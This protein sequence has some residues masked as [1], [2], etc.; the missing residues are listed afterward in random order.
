[1]STVRAQQHRRT[2]TETSSMK[3]TSTQLIE[4]PL[5][6]H[7]SFRSFRIN[8]HLIVMKIMMMKRKK[9]KSKTKMMMMKKK[10]LK[11]RRLKRTKKMTQISILRYRQAV[12]IKKE[13]K[14]LNK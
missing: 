11:T 7:T 6:S 10:K 8:F 12:T 4:H 5:P 3:K 2:S 9:N 13:K 14:K 1:V